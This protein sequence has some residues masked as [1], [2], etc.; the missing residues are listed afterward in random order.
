MEQDLLMKALVQAKRMGNLLNEV[1]DLTQQIAESVDRN[2]QVSME[3]LVAMRREPINKLEETEQALRDLAETYPDA[4]LA[5]ELIALINGEPA[6]KPAGRALEEQI[7]SNR[8][9]LTQILQLDRV[10]NKRM[11]REKSVYQ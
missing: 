10:L 3:M 4:E 7:A 6:T 2:D 1:Q 5:L 11:A 9:R 8:R